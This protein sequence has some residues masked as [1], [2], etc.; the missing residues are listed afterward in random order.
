M[1]LRAMAPALI[2]LEATGGFETAL[3]AAVAAAALP[4][5]VANPRQ[6]RDFAT[7]TGPLAK[8]DRL[9]AQVLAL[10][11]ARVRP[12]PR[13]LPDAVLQHL[14]ALMTRRRQLLDMLT[15]EGN[16][17]EQAAAPIRREI[18]RH[19]RWLK[20]RVAAVERDLDDTIQKSPVWRAKED[21]LRTVT[22]VDPV[23]SR[24]LLADLPELGQRN[25]KQIAAR[26]GVALLA[27][28]SGT[29]RGKRGAWGRRA[30][31]RAVLYRGALVATQRNAVIR[32]FYRRLVEAGK[33]KKVA[34][35]AC[36]R[37]LLT[38]LNAVMR[39]NTTSQ[40]S[41]LDFA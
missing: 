19:V 10:F 26:V 7:A 38:I 8:T 4:V 23:L 18:A 11:A 41:Q 34:L 12:A 1:R 15:A 17:L 39:A 33:P 27:R 37:K 22:G 13:P 2:V 31:V 6:V 36:M 20:R 24:T 3:V 28:G 40:A 21:L 25:R 35:V 16:R 14:E 32:A 9:D 5:V 30:P 29:F